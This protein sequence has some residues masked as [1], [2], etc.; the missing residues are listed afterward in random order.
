MELL[1]VIFE[2]VYDNV[3]RR[4]KAV[5]RHE[6][7]RDE[8]LEQDTMSPSLFP[9]ALASVCSLWRHVMLSVPKFWGRV[10]ILID[11]PAPLS[12][13]VSQFWSSRDRQLDVIV[14]RSAFHDAV[15]RRHERSQIAAIMDII[16]SHIHRIRE[17]HI[18]VMFSS[19]LPFPTDFYGTATK[20]RVLELQSKEDDGG[21][22][23]ESISLTEHVKFLCPKLKSFVIDGRMFYEACWGDAQW[24]R[25]IATV[26]SLTISHFQP[27]PGES[28][29]TDQLMRPLTAL[30]SLDTLRI[31]DTVLC[32]SPKSIDDPDLPWVNYLDFDGLIDFRVMD[33][34]IYL[35]VDPYNISFTR[36]GLEHITD[37]FQHFGDGG[38]LRLAEINHDLAPLLRLWI[39][40]ALDIADC[41]GF[42]D[43]L[44]D[45]MASKENGV[46]NCAKRLKT[47]T[48][49]NCPNF[50]VVALRRF[51]QSRPR[52]DLQ[53]LTSV[54]PFTTP[55]EHV[56]LSGNVPI[57][58]QADVAWFDTNLSSFSST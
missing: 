17:L 38:E 34:I 21:S 5:N 16:G 41:P 31:V 50:S 45:T 24:S 29:S 58:S 12:G 14:T 23:C 35:M 48:I 49:R 47:M 2:L 37:V 33:Q 53:V 52:W 56:H 44:L 10:V 42:N 13:V 18:N 36:C 40:H 54:T 6:Q 30:R 46:F 55:I 15:D 32:P 28:F 9:Y 8:W 39:G 19:S 25:K 11:P 27:R 22:D 3:Y 4:H 57:V 43:V 26:K 51:V 7:D 1:L 20:L